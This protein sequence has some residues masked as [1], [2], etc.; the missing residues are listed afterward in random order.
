MVSSIPYMIIEEDTTTMTA[1]M[2]E[3]RK[4]RKKMAEEMRNPI[5]FSFKN[6]YKTTKKES[7]A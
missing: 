3:M 4:G 1:M 7:Q 5:E 2:K 6:Q